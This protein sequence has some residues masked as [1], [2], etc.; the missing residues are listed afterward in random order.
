MTS[1]S[2]IEKI[3]VLIAFIFILHAQ[4]IIVDTPPAAGYEISLY[5]AYP[6]YLWIFILVALS[7]GLGLL[8]YRAFSNYSSKWWIFGLIIPIYINLLILL[9][10]YI[11]GYTTFGR[12]DVLE[13]IGYIKDILNTGNFPLAGMNG[14]NYYPV[15]HI[16]GADLSYITGLTPE[17]LAETYPGLF[18][19]FYLVSV[20]LLARSIAH[21]WRETLLITAF[22]S[23][24][25]FEYISLMLSPSVIC[26][27]LLPFNLFLFNR[28]ISSQ[29]RVEFSIILILMFL[30][31]PF[32]HPGEGTIFLFLFLIFIRLSKIFCLEFNQHFVNEPSLACA[33]QSPETANSGLILIITWFVWFSAYSNFDNKIIL[34]WNW[35]ST[36]SGM[37]KAMEYGAI[38]SIANLSPVEF[39]H[40]LF[41]MHGQK[42]I[43]FIISC[44]III[45]FL[46][47]LLSHKGKISQTQFTYSF[48]FM[49]FG[50]LLFVAFLSNAIWVAYNREMIYLA[51]AATILNGLG[52]YDMFHSRHKKIGMACIMF[53]LV[54]SAYFSL[55]NTFPSPIERDFNWQVTD[56]EII[57]MGNFL[58]HYDAN[59]FVENRG[60]E[61]R[62]FAACV[63]GIQNLPKNIRYADEKTNPF[64]HF[65]YEMNESYGQ[66]LVE[67]RY[68]IEN[69]ISR[70][71]YP[72]VFPD[73]KQLWKFTPEDFYYLDNSDTSA[74]KFYCNGGFW[75]YYIKGYSARTTP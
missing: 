53:L 31:I 30:L 5:E 70:I 13:H 71:V 27:F 19:L 4:I 36:T 12:W 29:K 67:D 38:I 55:F 48:L 52:L 16:I 1:P 75:A 39:V 8:V 45:I 20:H 65:G 25:L 3:I 54:I 73:Y 68:F 34:I 63:M 57:G 7:C 35:L 26:F 17:L 6:F 66:S 18:T 37:T 46:R 21:G 14:S 64:D 43:Y 44:A 11:R 61:Q 40:L 50:V 9:L 72:E 69:K 47:R 74:S 41:Y 23:L 51:F 2:R 60:L 58:D 22:G 59:L 49:I 62:P 15:V 10:P 32:L 42:L 24:L 56:T 28:K 33:S